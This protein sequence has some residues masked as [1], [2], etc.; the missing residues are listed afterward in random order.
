MYNTQIYQ[1]TLYI[2]V[3]FSNNLYFVK[4]IIDYLH[5]VLV[6]IVLYNYIIYLIILQNSHIANLSKYSQYFRGV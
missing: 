3:H 5:K 1:K 6:V 4:L 2:Y